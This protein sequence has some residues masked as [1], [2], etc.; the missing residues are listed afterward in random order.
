MRPEQNNKHVAHSNSDP[1]HMPKLNKT[2]DWKRLFAFLFCYANAKAVH[3][4]FVQFVKA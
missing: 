4:K 2:L 3:W 1:Y